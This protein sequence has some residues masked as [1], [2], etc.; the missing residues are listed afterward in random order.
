MTPQ[1][2]EIPWIV[3][4]ELTNLCNLECVFCDHPKLKKKMKM[5]EMESVLLEKILS[6]DTL[7]VKPVK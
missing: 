7:Q 3:N 1:K 5:K 2:T 4:I 6:P